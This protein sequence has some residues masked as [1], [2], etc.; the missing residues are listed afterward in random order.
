MEN[1]EDN[2]EL[3]NELSNEALL[4]RSQVLNALAKRFSGKRLSER[5]AKDGSLE[6][7]EVIERMKKGNEEIPVRYINNPDSKS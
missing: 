5:K 7:K 1:K 2:N 4:M 3:H 6:Y